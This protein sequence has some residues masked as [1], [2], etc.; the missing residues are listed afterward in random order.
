MD[1]YSTYLLR[2]FSYF[3]GFEYFLK[4]KRLCFIVCNERCE[5]ISKYFCTEGQAS[6]Q[7]RTKV[8]IGEGEIKLTIIADNL[9]LSSKVKTD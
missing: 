5:I 2:F 7:K 4:C 1:F 8:K 3:I 9:S 6:S